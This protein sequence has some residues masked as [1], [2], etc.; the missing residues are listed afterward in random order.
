MPSN[1]YIMLFLLIFSVNLLNDHGDATFFKY[2]TM[3]VLCMKWAISFIVTE[4]STL[5]TLDN[6]PFDNRTLTL[7]DLSGI[8]NIDYVCKKI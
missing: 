1:V 2:N 3:F 7:C 6:F 8:K 5:D 4:T